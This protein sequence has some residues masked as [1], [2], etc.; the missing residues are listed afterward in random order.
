M[1]QWICALAGCCWLTT[2]SAQAA[3]SQSVGSA[4]INEAF[5]TQADNTI[6]L[7]AADRQPPAALEEEI[8]PCNSEGVDWIAGYWD[9][10][11]LRR[12][13]V[14]INGVWRRPP[15]GHHW[16]AGFWRETPN[17][18]A[19]IKGFWSAAPEDDLHYISRMPPDPLQE[20]AGDPPGENMFWMPGYWG[21]SEADQTFRWYAGQWAAVDN[22]WVFV[23]AHWLWRPAGY[24]FVP[25]YWDY[26]LEQRGCAY[27]AVAVQ[28]GQSTVSY[29][30]L[31]PL[32]PDA[33]V[34]ALF[35]Y[36]P[37]YLVFFQQHYYTHRPFWDRYYAT[38]PWWGWPTWWT[39][40]W[41]DQWWLFWWW[42]HPGFPQP[43]F[44]TIPISTRIWPPTTRFVRRMAGIS[45][46]AVVTATGVVRPQ[47][48][49]RQVGL[50]PGQP[51]GRV[52]PVIPARAAEEQPEEQPGAA[53]PQ[54]EG[55][56]PLRPSGRPPAPGERAETTAGP[57]PDIQFQTPPG[58]Q[59]ARPARVPRKPSEQAGPPA[60]PNPPRQRRGMVPPVPQPGGQLRPGQPP[61]SPSGAQQPVNQPRMRQSLEKR[62]PNY[63]PGAAESTKTQPSQE[64]RV[65]QEAPPPGGQ[66]EFQR[67]QGAPQG[68][69]PQ[70]LPPR[71]AYGPA[72]LQSPE[73]ERSFTP[74][75]D[76]YLRLEPQRTPPSQAPGPSRMENA[77]QPSPRFTPEQPRPQ[78]SGINPMRQGGMRQ[79][80]APDP[81][82][83][84][85][86]RSMRLATETVKGTGQT[87]MSRPALA[88]QEASTTSEPLWAEPEAA[89]SITAELPRDQT[90]D[91]AQ[92]STEASP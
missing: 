32:E 3:E 87:T 61:L 24:L 67:P 53:Q 29:A 12:Q 13:F 44:I 76:T 66:V 30:S 72:P 36:Y 22:T 9:W 75:P 8:P 1:R 58:Q 73:E 47:Q 59:P 28:P 52:E 19:R 48:L 11:D 84:K 27:P 71:P 21:Y 5:V 64:V 38:P 26:P 60:Q 82:G 16:I 43:P 31:E 34:D 89:E 83:A 45:P 92:A 17:G 49:F 77:P 56:R 57:R 37:N 25:S 62:A 2:L 18:W 91:L 40:T 41:W 63:P 81:A 23:P 69:E 65:L 42:A 7:A 14:W 46:P 20:E 85:H 79:T 51:L 70:P 15:P 54:R 35:P 74:P 55:V 90:G 50:Q 4:P 10:S 80:R 88:K 68:P 39:I 6:V 33:I 86:R 78:G